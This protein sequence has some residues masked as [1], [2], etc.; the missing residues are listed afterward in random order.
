MDIVVAVVDSGVDATHP[1]LAANIWT[2]PNETDNGIDD[3]G[4]GYIDDLHG[5]DFVEDDKH[6]TDT[7]GHGTHVAGILVGDGSSAEMDDAGFLRGLGGVDM[8]QVY[9]DIDLVIDTVA[10]AG[11]ARV[12]ARMVPLAV[13]KG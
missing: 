6:P 10:G 5:W 3:D 2:N 8:P 9:K 1:D 12:V 7:H 4:N 11:L 13:L